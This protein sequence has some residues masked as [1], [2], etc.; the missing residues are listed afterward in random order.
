MSKEITEEILLKAGFKFTKNKDLEIVKDGHIINLF[1]RKS[2]HV[3]E[4]HWYCRI[5]NS[6]WYIRGGLDIQT[7]SHFNKLMDLMGIDFRL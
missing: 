4:R 2:N 5:R 3:D 1:Y 6:D 7:I